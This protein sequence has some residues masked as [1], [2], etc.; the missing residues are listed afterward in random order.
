ML[1]Y[2]NIAFS[3][4][5][6]MFRGLLMA[7]TS[8]CQNTS[9]PVH[10]YV[11]TGDFLDIDPQF[12]SFDDKMIYYYQKVI[13]LFNP[14]NLITKVDYSSYKEEL[15]KLKDIKSR[16]TI[17]AFFRLFFDMLPDLPDKILYLDI[18]TVALKDI[19][20]LYDIDMRSKSVALALD[21][22]G[23][24]WLNPHYCNSGVMLM[25]LK[26]IRENNKL[27][28]CRNMCQKKHMFMPDQ[29]AINKYFNKDIRIL[30]NIYN[31]QKRTEENTVIRH[32]CTIFKVFPYI[33]YVKSKPWD[34]LDYFHNERKEYQFDNLIALVNKLEKAFNEEKEIDES[35]L[36]PDVVYINL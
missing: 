1:E 34:E 16:F 14:E 20:S 7:I 17:Y 5:K 30:S 28:K 23:H 26:K 10:I 9:K 11:M 21:A 6:K 29:S 13:S 4:N 15:Y 31:E 8:I 27:A 25:D 24:K 35:I 36:N 18:D 2:I 33:H 12:V 3:G 19:S 22:V 32:F